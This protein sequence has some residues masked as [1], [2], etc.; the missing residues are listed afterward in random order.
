MI[1][2]YDHT[3]SLEKEYGITGPLAFDYGPYG[4]PSLRDYPHIHFNLSHCPH[5]ALC[6][7]GDTPVG[8]DIETVP[9]SLDMD[10]CR[11]VFNPQ[12]LNSLLSAPSPAV[13]FASLWTQKEAFL[14]FTGEGM[15]HDLK[16]L[17]LSPRALSVSFETVVSPDRTYLYTVCR[18]KFYKISLAI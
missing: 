12:E 3:E 11:H 1:Y 16:D 14:K 7:V 2:L 13:A 9:S 18:P 10:I 17:L 5:T 8:C 15:A 6:V 4:K